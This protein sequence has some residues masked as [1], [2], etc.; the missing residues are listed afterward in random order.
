MLVETLS[1]GWRRVRRTNT[2]DNGFPSRLIQA[3]EPVGDGSNVSQTVSSAV[4]DLGSGGVIAQ[5]GV[6]FKPYGAGADN[7]TFSMRV[8]G[9]RKMIEGGV[10]TTAVWEPTDLC[11]LL[12][13][14]SAVPIG[15]AGKVIVATDLF[16]DT[17]AIVGTTAN[18]GVSIDVHSPANDRAGFVSLDVFGFQKIEFIFT[19]GASATNCNALAALI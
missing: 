10:E 8:I 15:L 14:L 2:T 18:A 5:N 17:I 16:A 7:A 19:T 12:C 3:A 4:I 13:T 9:W 1:M 6:I 11:E